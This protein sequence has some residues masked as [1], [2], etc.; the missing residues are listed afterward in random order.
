[1]R[2]HLISSSLGAA[3]PYHNKY[4]FELQRHRQHDLAASSLAWLDIYIAPQLSRLDGVVVSMTRLHYRQ[5]DSAS[6]SYRGEVAL[7][8]S[9]PTWLGSTIANM[10]WHL[11]RVA[12][13]S[14]RYHHHQHDS[15]ALSPAWLD[16]Y[17]ASQLSCLSDGIT[18]MTRQH[19]CEHDLTST[20]R[21]GQATSA[22]SS[23]ARLN[24]IV[25]SM[26]YYLHHATT[27]VALTV[28]SSTWLDSAI[29]SMTRQ[30]CR[31]HDLTSISRHDELHLGS[32]ITS[33]TRQ[34]RRQQDS[35]Q[36]RHQ[37]DSTAPSPAW[38]SIDVTQLLDH[39]HQQYMTSATS[40]HA[41]SSYWYYS[42]LCLV[43]WYYSQL[44]L[45]LGTM[46]ASWC[47]AWHLR[48][49]STFQRL[50]FEDFKL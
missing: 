8:A 30:H 18:S 25:S 12:N 2:Q 36:R 41:V 46:Q 37:H 20:L 31:Q 9:S 21:H 32:A 50:T 43:P 48:E 19:C 4:N 33:R 42:Q 24:S 34:H 40:R 22:A 10:T 1:M 44:C 17:I 6:T 47:A 13:K 3:Q 27:N 14:H 7:A 49:A 15:T 29:A 28:P 16:I 35:R 23:P 45:V 38:L 5:H 11:H 39:E 26:T